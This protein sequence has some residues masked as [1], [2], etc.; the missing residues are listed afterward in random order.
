MLLV[1]PARAQTILHEENRFRTPQHW[2]IELR[3]GPYAPEIDTEF[4]G[5]TD[6]LPYKTYFGD[7]HHLLMQLELD[8]QFFH[9]F[10]TAAVGLQAGYFWKSTQ[11]LT[12]AGDASGDKTKLELFPMAIQAVYR[13]DSLSR[14]LKLP[15][16]P[17]GK[18]GLNYTVWRITDGNGDIPHPGSGGRGLGGTPGWQAA[19]GVAFLLDVLDPGAARAL[20][21]DTGVNHTYVF[22][23]VARYAAAGLGSSKVLHVGDTTWVLGL[24][25]EF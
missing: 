11:A 6:H 13:L 8:Y 24:M 19:A 15:L 7:K 9:S 4:K 20:D 16:A 3:F 10:G 17:Y 23:E 22:G 18:L 1:A 2:A 12:L 21:D 5:P 14:N 25:F